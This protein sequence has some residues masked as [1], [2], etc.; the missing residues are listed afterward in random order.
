[1]TEW[2]DL[3]MRVGWTSRPEM[4]VSRTSMRIRCYA[5]WLM[6]IAMRRI[7][8]RRRSHANGNVHMQGEIQINMVV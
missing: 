3:S 8:A 7:G 1:M 6:Q 2:W 4:H 5:H